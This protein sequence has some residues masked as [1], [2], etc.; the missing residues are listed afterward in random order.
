MAKRKKSSYRL[1]QRLRASRRDRLN[2]ITYLQSGG[3]GDGTGGGDTVEHAMLFAQA[4]NSG[5]V[6]YSSFE[7]DQFGELRGPN[8][9]PSNPMLALHT[10]PG[11]GNY[12]VFDGDAVDPLETSR[13]ILGESEVRINEADTLAYNVNTMRTQ[14]FFTN[15]VLVIEPETLYPVAVT[16]LEAK[17]ISAHFD[18]GGEMVAPVNIVHS[19]GGIVGMGGDMR[20]NVFPPVTLVATMELGGGM[21]ANVSRVTRRLGAKFD[22]GGSMVSDIRAGTPRLLSGIFTGGGEMIVNVNSA[23]PEG[24]ELTA[25]LA[26]MTVQPSVER[27]DLIDATITAL[28][29]AGIWEMLDAFYCYAAHDEQAAKLNWIN[30]AQSADEV[31]GDRT[32]FTMD[33]GFANLSYSVQ[34]VGYFDDG[35]NPNAGNTKF[36]PTN[37]M[38][39][40]R[41]ARGASRLDGA[42]FGTGDAA[43]TSYLLTTTAG[44]ISAQMNAPNLSTHRA[45]YTAPSHDTLIAM[46][47]DNTSLR[48]YTGGLNRATKVS[49]AAFAVPTSRHNVLSRLVGDTPTS[50][51]TQPVSFMGWGAS[52]AST[53]KHADL[54]TIVENYLNGL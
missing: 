32:L 30:P 22:G 21:A 24:A 13:L 29:T 34:P 46:Q 8:P 7:E 6:G 19:L 38:L 28:K 37:A 40:A 44:G 15:D 5:Y 33:V 43:N 16:G 17:T 31:S 52:L 20:A 3:D 23:I 12:A 48:L 4:S 2:Y 45:T 10:L 47:R 9:L 11:G 36:T 51:Y 1:S 35:F 42:L 14:V 53:I 54:S 50:G 27:V 39:F 18:G 25:L 41:P 26:A 49:T